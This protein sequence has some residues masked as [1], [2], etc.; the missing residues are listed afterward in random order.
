M[1]ILCVVAIEALIDG[2]GMCGVGAGRR[3]KVCA[4]YDGGGAA[5]AGKQ[6]FF[7]LADLC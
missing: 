6:K 4:G 5:Y 2:R 3:V 7:R 1:K